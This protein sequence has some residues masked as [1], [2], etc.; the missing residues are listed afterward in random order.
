VHGECADGTLVIEVDIHGEDGL[1]VAELEDRIGALD[2]RL[3]IER[4]IDGGIRI[5]AELPC[6]S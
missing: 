6:A 4:G 3:D 1:N 2:G 5:R